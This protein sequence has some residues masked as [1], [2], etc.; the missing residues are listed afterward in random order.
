V[1]PRDPI[2]DTISRYTSVLYGRCKQ[3]KQREDT[4]VLKFIKY[5]E[6]V[7]GNVTDTL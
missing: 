4:I 1:I 2:R 7:L 5:I 3:G 6:R